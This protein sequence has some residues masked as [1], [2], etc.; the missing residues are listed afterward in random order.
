MSPVTRLLNVN[1][2]QQAN[3]SALFWNLPV[4]GTSPQQ[5]PPRYTELLRVL[6]TLDLER[7]TPELYT[8]NASEGI[9]LA[10]SLSANE[11]PASVFQME[12]YFGSALDDVIDERLP[13]PPLEVHTVKMRFRFTG[14]GLPSFR[15]ATEIDPYHA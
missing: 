9:L 13:C 8:T 12:A 10:E 3:T 14:E 7:L 2:E 4:L 11:N 15:L 1:C 5:P 6:Q